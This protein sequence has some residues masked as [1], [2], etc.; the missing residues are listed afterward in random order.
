MLLYHKSGH[1]YMSKFLDPFLMKMINYMYESQ[2][3]GVKAAL[4]LV[5]LILFNK[6]LQKDQL[7]LQFLCD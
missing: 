2:A 7:E 4:G 5:H 1:K 6:H 3:G